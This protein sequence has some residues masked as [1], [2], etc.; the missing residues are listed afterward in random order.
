[1]K[2]K[3]IRLAGLVGWGALAILIVG[4]ILETGARL[5]FGRPLPDVLPDRETLF[6]YPA[7][8]ISYYWFA[9][10]PQGRRRPMPFRT[11]ALGLRDD[12]VAPKIPGEF[13]ILMLGDSFTAGMAIERMEDT[14]PR[15][16]QAMLRQ[17]LGT[18]A[19]TVMNGGLGNSA[20]Y[21]QYAL[22]RRIS[23]TIQPDLVI[24]QLY[25]SNDLSDT[26]SRMDL[27]LR[28]YN[29]RNFIRRVSFAR[30][31]SS[32]G[33]DAYMVLATQSA[34]WCHLASLLDMDVPEMYARVMCWVP[35]S[36]VRPLPPVPPTPH[37]FWALE[38]NLKA[39][40]PLLELA[41]NTLAADV[42]NIHEYCADHQI[43]VAGFAI[44]CVYSVD[45][46]RWN[47]DLPED[48]RREREP[49]KDA[50]MGDRLLERRGI[51]RVSL[52]HAITGRG[53][54]GKLYHYYDMHLNEEGARFTADVLADFLTGEV[55]R[56]AGMTP[57]SPPRPGNAS[58][59][60]GG[61]G[62]DGQGP[63]GEI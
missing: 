39:W 48:I 5:R 59:Q 61:T 18:S 11:N 9:D 6:R 33:G 27:H 15:Q 1:M 8:G 60:E 34:A 16:L 22:L 2:N 47:Q 3:L 12:P 29:P 10:G 41:Y 38:A 46:D 36:G 26:L 19:I 24:L 20:P 32:P 53:N 45:P 58:A 55:L 14:I 31:A 51:P 35:Y 43:R 54:G 57:E 42:A 23:S 21:Q 63:A 40:Y 52:Y 28:A 13:R 62:H 56:D 30:V 50:I 44:P 4:A 17:R 25:L 7:N 37:R 49:G